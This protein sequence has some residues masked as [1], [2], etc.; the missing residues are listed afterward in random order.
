MPRS[1]LRD[2]FG[3]CQWFHHGDEPSLRRT[4]HWLRELGVRHLRT[5]ISW[6]DYH[7]PG[8]PA[9]YERV[10]AAL[11]EFELL[12]SVWHTPPTLSVDGRCASHPATVPASRSARMSTIR[13]RSRST[14]IVP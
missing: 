14:M 3:L 10:F 9:W 5:G 2:R 7:L 1:T 6:A 8:A 4:V 11:A 13:R 12:V